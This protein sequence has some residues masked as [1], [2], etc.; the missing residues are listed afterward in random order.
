MWRRR[1]RDQEDLDYEDREERVVH[2]QEVRQNQ[3]EI[4]ALIE[5]WEEVTTLE[6]HSGW[7]SAE[8]LLRKALKDAHLKLE[9]ETDVKALC[10]WQGYSAALRVALEM[11]ATART[12]IRR[13]TD[14]LE[15]V[16]EEKADLTTDGFRAVS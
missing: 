7:A 12:E 13:L 16:L 11:P 6:G 8:Q 5:R 10:R 1:Q 15:S 9:T 3:D 4:E 2:A 14:Q